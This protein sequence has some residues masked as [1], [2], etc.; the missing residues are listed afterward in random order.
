MSLA[1]AQ[2]INVAPFSQI[3]RSP[4]FRSNNLFGE[5]LELTTERT[6]ALRFD[7]KS[8]KECEVRTAGR[9]QSLSRETGGGFGSGRASPYMG[10]I[11]R[12]QRM[13]KMKAGVTLFAIL[14]SGQFLIY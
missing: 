8:C 1:L 5:G 12:A 6:G 4:A 9:T 11:S 2:I 10:A 14:C 3:D 13:I 7:T